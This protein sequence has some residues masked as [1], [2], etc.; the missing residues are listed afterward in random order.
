MHGFSWLFHVYLQEL[1][2]DTD[3]RPCILHR[4]PQGMRMLRQTQVPEPCRWGDVSATSRPSEYTT[5]TVSK[6]NSQRALAITHHMHASRP[7]DRPHTPH[8]CT[9]STL[10]HR[11]RPSST[12]QPHLK[13]SMDR[14]AKVPVLS[15]TGRT[16]RITQTMWLHNS[17]MNTST[18][19][20]SRDPRAPCPHLRL[21]PIT[22]PQHTR[23][24]LST[25][26][27][28]DLISGVPRAHSY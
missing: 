26:H 6:S 20:T 16:R 25:E 17:V 3:R 8:R 18:P 22:S 21:F 23:L 12:R 24:L 11:A 10:H 14:R 4:V 2:S 9:L 7:F 1:F 5:T 19:T 28:D 15:T 13:T 27:A